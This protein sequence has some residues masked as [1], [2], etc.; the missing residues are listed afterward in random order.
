MVKEKYSELAVASLALEMAALISLLL[1]VNTTMYLF[2]FVG[3]ALSISA[4]VM[5]VFGLKQI[6][7]NKKLKERKLVLLG[8]LFGVFE[9]TFLL[10]IFIWTLLLYSG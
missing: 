3:I 8:I 6:K 10:F 7:K 9:L 4:I 2:N 5:G 1:F